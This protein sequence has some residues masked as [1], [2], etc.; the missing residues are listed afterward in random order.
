LC[1]WH[2]APL[3]T[4]VQWWH[5]LLQAFGLTQIAHLCT[6]HLVYL[7]ENLMQHNVVLRQVIVQNFKM[8]YYIQNVY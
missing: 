8:M 4:H 2:L 3:Q 7:L 6:Q 1:W 5:H